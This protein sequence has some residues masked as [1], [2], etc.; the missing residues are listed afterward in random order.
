MTEDRSARTFPTTASNL[1]EA[2]STI[3]AGHDLEKI[4]VGNEPAVSGGLGSQV[5]NAQ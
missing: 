4:V 1:A 5:I 3:E 2:Q